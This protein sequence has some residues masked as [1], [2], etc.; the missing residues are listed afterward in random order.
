[1]TAQ[2]RDDK[3]VRQGI[4][5]TDG[6]G[7]RRANQRIAEEE[8]EE[9]KEE[10]ERGAVNAAAEI[11]RDQARQ[12]RHAAALGE[13]GVELVAPSGN[14]AVRAAEQE[15]KPAAIAVASRNLI[16]EAK[17]RKATARARIAERRNASS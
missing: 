8:A 1:M 6:V 14:A 10:A 15:E 4:S 9:K 13:Q 12:R 16:Q 2:N 7:R 3:N 5:S 17:N 11:A